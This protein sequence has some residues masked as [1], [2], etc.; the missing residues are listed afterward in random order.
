[1]GPLAGL[2]V[3]EMA[4]IGPCPLAGQLLADLGAEVVV[5]ARAGANPFDDAI[6]ARGKRHLT[7][8]LKHDD[9]RA[10]ALA[11]IGRADVLI[12]G[13]RP[14]VMERLGLG[15][16]ECLAA[17]PGLV[18]GRV[19]GW[20][21]DGPL[22][23]AAGH[24]I[25]YI[26]VTGALNALGEPDRPPPPPL[27][28][29]GDYAGGTMFLLTGVLAA[30]FERSRSGRG[31]VIDAAMV[32]GVPALMGL[33]HSFRAIGLWSNERGANL[34]DGGAPWYRCY[35]TADGRYVSVGALEPQFFAAMARRLGLEER[36]H[37]DRM[38]RAKWP[39]L[40][41]LLKRIFATKARDEWAA[42]FEGTDCCVAPVLDWDEAPG[43]PHLAARGSF[44]SAGGVTQAAP[45]P[46]FS[47][48]QPARPDSPRD[49]DALLDELG[50][51]SARMAGLRQ[52][53]A[54]S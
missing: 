48:T 25:N 41:A 29:F 11:L 23:H 54:I 38:D 49:A 43:H 4:G 46:R 36:W 27:N 22:A 50:Y 52:A 35:A 9:G 14:G 26:A 16:D 10:L 31:Q 47:R 3:V 17:N 30:L 15:P 42:V 40:A 6:N 37:A 34:L 32:D 45:A 19:T 13:F 18:Y 21:Q 51:D 28:L 24:D 53:G 39:E 2:R 33:F 8:N 12:E 44:F 1:M 7:I 20:G 5:I